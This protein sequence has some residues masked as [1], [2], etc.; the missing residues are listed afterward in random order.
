MQDLRVTLVQSG[1]EWHDPE[2][3]L[4]RFGGLIG[5]LAE[6]TDLVVLPE[7]FTTGFIMQARDYAEDMAGRTVTRLREWARN[8]DADIAG[9]LIVGEGG[10]YFNRLVWAKP[11]GRIVTYDKRHLFRMAGEQSVYSAGTGK[12]VIELRGWKLR[13]FICY[14]LRFPVWSR[15]VKNEYD[16]AVFVANWPEQRARHWSALLRARAI[17]NQCYVIGV[18]RVGT[19][20]NG[21]AYAGGSTVI[22]YEGKAIFE[23]K[24]EE[25]AR[26][27]VLLY[28]LLDEYRS[29]FPAWKDADGFTLEL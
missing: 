2:A 12:P 22:D 6:A 13:P 19:D 20:G 1:I 5:S 17:E 10:R 18:N 7:M 25:G 9:S 24:D 21:P 8:I 15:N 11:D 14:D 23:N 16:A 28:D 27:V 4:A 26:T 29:S 3:N